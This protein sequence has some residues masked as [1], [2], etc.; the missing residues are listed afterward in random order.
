[1]PETKY[2]VM[3]RGYQEEQVVYGPTADKAAADK[4]ASEHAARHVVE[5]KEK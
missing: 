2:V 5:R 1:M 3:Q 4:V